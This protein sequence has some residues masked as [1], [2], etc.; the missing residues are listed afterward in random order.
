[1]DAS[2]GSMETALRLLTNKSRSTHELMVLLEEKQFPKDDISETITKLLEWGYL[3]DEKYAELWIENRQHHKPMG[4][5]RLAS[6][7][8][9]KGIS[10]AIIQKKIEEFFDTRPEFDI[11][12]ELASSYLARGG[13]N[14]KKTTGYLS[15]RGFR[16][17]TINAL[18]YSLDPEDQD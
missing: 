10:E 7:L 9:S 8:R 15:R 4:P 11:A 18:R 3:N 1:M 14:W 13:S 5:I 17:E 2:A 6:E 16:F 12:I